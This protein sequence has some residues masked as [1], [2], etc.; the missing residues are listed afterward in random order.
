[1]EVPR[2]MGEGH[3]KE[4]RWLVIIT[5]EERCLCTSLT[6]AGRRGGSATGSA[7]LRVRRMEVKEAAAR[8]VAADGGGG[9]VA[10]LATSTS[11]SPSSPLLLVLQLQRQQF[12]SKK[13]WQ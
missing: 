7:Q 5:L 6:P 13:W 1:M 12:V 11:S 2:R 4:R 8:M 10:L 3:R 9:D